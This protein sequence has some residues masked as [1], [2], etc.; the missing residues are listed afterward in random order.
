[1]EQST[2]PA[3]R[4]G[5]HTRTITTS[6][7][8]ALTWSSAA[9]ASSDSVFRAPYTNLLTYLLTYKLLCK[10]MV[11]LTVSNDRLSV[12]NGKMRSF[13]S[14]MFPSSHSHSHETSLM[15]PIP[16]GIQWDSWKIREF[17][18]THDR[19][20]CF[21]VSYEPVWRT[22]KSDDWITSFFARIIRLTVQKFQLF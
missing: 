12:G 20:Q 3:V 4:A 22:G 5:Y 2:S 13:H 10:N 16:R 17:P 15:I 14:L 9:A 1:M 7:Q 19:K 11:P 8:S 18:T 21:F 6:T